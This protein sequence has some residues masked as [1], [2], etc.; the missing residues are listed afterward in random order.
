[1]T[2]LHR[3]AGVNRYEGLSPELTGCSDDAVT[4]QRKS[5]VGSADIWLRYSP[6]CRTIWAHIS[7]ARRGPRTTRAVPP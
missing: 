7:G 3:M 1:M 4:I 5:I 2:R 6:R